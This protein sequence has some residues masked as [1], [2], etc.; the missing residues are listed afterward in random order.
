MKPSPSTHEFQHSA[1]QRF[2]E[3]L[4]NI[5]TCATYAFRKMNIEIREDAVQDVI[6]QCYFAFIRLLRQG[7]GERAFPSVLARFAIRRYRAGRR[8]SGAV[9]GRGPTLETIQKPDHRRRLGPQE[10]RIVRWREMLMEDRR[11]PIP[12]Q[13]SFRVDFP[14][15]LKRLTHNQRRCAELLANGHQGQEVAQQLRM[16]PARISQVRRELRAEWER[17]HGEV[18]VLHK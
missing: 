5:R 7:K 16:T 17:F 14:E 18:A 12:D 11:T 13:V 6:V 8:A 2:Q 9:A 10:R 15:W 3:I 1:N 4:P